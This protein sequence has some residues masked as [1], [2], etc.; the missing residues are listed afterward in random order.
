MGERE[1]IRNT[2][3]TTI[4]SGEPA[5]YKESDAKAIKDKKPLIQVEINYMHRKMGRQ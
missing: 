5:L 2:G 4:I 1:G 3:A